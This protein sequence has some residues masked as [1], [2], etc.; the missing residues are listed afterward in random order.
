MAH[1][2]FDIKILR[3]MSKN[4][5]HIRFVG[6]LIG[7]S[8]HNNVDRPKSLFILKLSGY[9]VMPTR[10][11]ISIEELF[12]VQPLRQKASTEPSVS[13]LVSFAEGYED[14]DDNTVLQASPGAELTIN[15]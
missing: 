5:S 7:A 6:S 15:K 12:R 9:G 10:Q 3:E 2:N 1:T 4:V 13:T 14:D 8:T 11:V